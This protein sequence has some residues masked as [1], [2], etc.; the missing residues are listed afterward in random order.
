MDGGEFED[1]T[2]NLE[3]KAEEIVQSTEEREEK[4]KRTSGEPR[5][6]RPRSWH[7]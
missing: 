2:S 6:P 3:D 1:H 7:R 4:G 5:R